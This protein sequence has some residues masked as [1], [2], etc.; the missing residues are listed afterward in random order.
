[1]VKR[2]LITTALEET[3]R[4]D[5][6][7]LLLGE[8]C[9]LHHRRDQWSRLQAEI[10]PYHWDDRAKL[11]SDFHY[12]RGLH[13]QLLA[14]LT[15]HLN[16]IHG[17]KHS[18]RYWRIL[19]GP[20]LGYFVQILFDR[21]TSIQQA[22]ENYEICG[23]VV[24]D[25]PIDAVVPN[26]MSSFISLFTSDIWNH[27][28]FGAILKQ[29][30]SVAIC[31]GKSASPALKTS[32]IGQKWELRRMLRFCLDSAL[33]MTTRLSSE[34][35]VFL[36]STYMPAIEGLE[37]QLR[38]GQVPQYW[39][40]VPTILTPTNGAR[41][42]WCLRGR[43]NTPFERCARALI[44]SQLPRA[45]LEGYSQLVNQTRTLPW[46][47]KPRLIWTS[48]CENADDVFKAWA[49]EKV[50]KGS[51]LL[52]GQHGGH[53]G[54]GLWSFTEEHQIAISDRYLTWGWETPNQ[55]KVTQL[56]QFKSRRP[57]G[58]R[59]ATQPDA[60]LVTMV[61]PRYSYWMYSAIVSR[62]WLD[63][64]EDQCS[65]VESL[66]PRIREALVVR[67]YA[68]DYGWDQVSRWRERFPKIRI[69][70]GWSKISGL[71]R[72]SRIF[73][74][75][76]NATTYLESFTMNVPTIIYW[77]CK[78]W[79]LRDSA[80]AFFDELKSVGIFHDT[81]ESA[82]RHLAAVWNDVDAW[83]TEPTV[84]RIVNRFKKCYCHLPDDLV[85]RVERTIREILAEPQ[86][87]Q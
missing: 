52:I 81:P 50:E 42:K 26:D 82:A 83:W 8:W 33:R 60:L 36:L 62:Q 3:W 48:N 47:R 51:Q 58:V 16:E 22:F 29:S 13:E 31:P 12:L 25:D 11:Y 65:F 44:S 35:D 30:T 77:N 54:Q 27:H 39:Q 17:A 71:I 80:K 34:D 55:P 28:I 46:P 37:L 78:H 57:L 79:E 20:W 15:D 2:F 75:T 67:L 70:L 73:I 24:L 53:Y 40:S 49:A 64:F 38:L 23:T 59:H 43:N 61:V 10:L 86:A 56:G 32:S 41:R 74:S 63:Y 84:L 18:S 19:I 66:P 5:E 68:S 21:W 7:T 9:R 4:Y 87:K 6:P 85:V 72:R 69:D 1:M 14:E 45:Y 76:Y